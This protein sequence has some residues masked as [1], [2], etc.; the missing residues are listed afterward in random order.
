MLGIKVQVARKGYDVRT[1]SA[2]NMAYDKKYAL[3]KFAKGI[4]ATTDGN[5]AHGMGIK[6]RVLMIKELQASPKQMGYALINQSAYDHDAG[7]SIGDGNSNVLID[8]TNINVN[9]GT[10]W[11]DFTT[12]PYSTAHNSAMY[13][14]VMQE[15]LETPSPL[16]TAPKNHFPLIISG[17]KTE[18]D[19]GRAIDTRYDTL[20][21]FKTGQLSIS[22]A[23]WTPTGVG[24]KTQVTETSYTHNLGYC[25]LF[26][27]FVD[28][29]FSIPYYNGWMDQ[30]NIRNGFWTSGVVYHTNER[31]QDGDTAYWYTCIKSN[32]ASASNKPDSGASWETYW[33]LY[34]S[35]PALW[36]TSHSYLV[37][38]QVAVLY[39][40][41]SVTYYWGFYKCISNHTSSADKK[42]PTG[43]S[44][45]TYWEDISYVPATSQSIYLNDLE[46]IKYVF[47]G[48]MGDNDEIIQFYSTE[49][50]LIMKLTQVNNDSIWGRTPSLATTV[51][52]DYTIF[53]NRADDEY[54]LLS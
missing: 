16:P 29:E 2:L 11:T 20:K 39:T 5:I 35:A 33:V 17:T 42:P 47:G 4:K 14:H 43:A 50:K 31:V 21:V 18:P 12:T 51:T 46:D 23:E 10:H 45:W 38:D 44:C 40:Y 8:D 53:C 26:S 24:R 30:W 52:V 7:L 22:V 36:V 28:Y 49:D 27:P 9:L 3:S 13:A 19:Y 34:Q 1:A 6:P 41:D 54:N 48:V 32:T 37:N 25:P 15:A